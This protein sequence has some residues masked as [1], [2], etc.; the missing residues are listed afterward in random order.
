MG[1]PALA[2]QR[3]HHRQLFG[4]ADD[5]KGV[6]IAQEIVHFALLVGRIE[7]VI[8]E[9]RLQAREIETQAL[10]RF[11]DLHGDPTARLRAQPLQN[12]GDL[13][14]ASDDLA[15]AVAHT[16]G[17]GQEFSIWRRAQRA[18]DCRKEIHG[19]PS[20]AFTQR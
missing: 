8:D 19:Q 20:S 13:R 18:L 11:V 4:I 7:R 9:A 3:L 5:R 12:I 10:D 16:L 2:G 14:G 1:D 15:P 17:S 6:R